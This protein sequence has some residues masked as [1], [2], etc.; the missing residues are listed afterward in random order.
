MEPTRIDEQARIVT[1]HDVVTAPPRAARIER[2]RSRNAAIRDDRFRP[3]A[4][5]WGGDSY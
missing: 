2:E 1:T 3:K 5:T 4:I